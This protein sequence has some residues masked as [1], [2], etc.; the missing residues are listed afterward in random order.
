[1]AWLQLRVGTDPDHAELVEDLLMGLGAVSVTLEDAADQPLY[2][3][4]PGTTPLWHQTSV[5][6]LF[7]ADSDMEA[8]RRQLAEQYHERTQHP[9]G[10]VALEVVE[11]K[12][13]TR[14]WMDDFQPLRFGERL[15][16]CPS[17]HQPPDPGA[18]TLM[19]DPG[20]AFGTGTH[21]TTALCLEWLDGARIADREVIDY[22][23]GSG[24]LGLAALLLGARSV[25]GIDTDPQALEASR[26]NASR[27][28]VSPDKLKLFLPDHTPQLQCDILLAN[29]LAEPL[30]ALA[31]QLADLVRP[32][33]ELVLS[34]I[35]ESQADALTTRYE[36]WFA[37]DA[38]ILSEGWVRLNGIRRQDAG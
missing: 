29:I 3:P 1:M 21:P 30:L 4:E 32:G 23:C 22:G 26:E 6:G 12:D 5:V 37:M 14:A 2:E 19:L 9:L 33:G 36:P 10:D 27:N 7:A 24:V 16:I 17:W 13:W 34:G 15:W 8:L 25:A 28:G 11:D 18:V 31:P 20:L 38:P 35:L